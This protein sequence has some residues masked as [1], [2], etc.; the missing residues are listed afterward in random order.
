MRA[1]PAVLGL[2][3]S[4][5]G[6]LTL[7]TDH[8]SAIKAVSVWVLVVIVG[9][10]ARVPS[11]GHFERTRAPMPWGIALSDQKLT[12]PW[13]PLSSA[14]EYK[15]CF[16]NLGFTGSS[17]QVLLEV[18]GSKPFDPRNAGGTATMTIT[19]SAGQVD[20]QTTGTLRDTDCCDLPGLNRWVSEYFHYSA[21][22]AIDTTAAYFGKPEIRAKV[23]RFGSYC[24]ALKISKGSTE[25]KDGQVRIIL[26]SGWK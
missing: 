21:G 25:V 1:Q 19:N 22:P 4:R 12:L 13:V 18:A 14:G 20:Y 7:R 23:R 24:V 16:A 10:C 17:A 8:P 2:R 5:C 3:A 15:W 9:G 26:Q 11:G 6:R